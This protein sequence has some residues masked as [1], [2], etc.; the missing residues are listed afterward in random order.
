MTN[1]IWIIGAVISGALGAYTVMYVLIR[2]NALRIQRDAMEMFQ[3]TR[4]ECASLKSETL[5]K[6]ESERYA[7]RKEIEQYRIEEKGRMEILTVRE[8]RLERIEQSIENEKKLLSLEKAKVELLRQNLETT[9]REIAFAQELLQ[10]E[11]ERIAGL[12]Q[13]QALRELLQSTE[14]MYAEDLTARMR[15][16]ELQGNQEWEQRARELLANALQ[17]YAAPHVAETSTTVVNLPADDY[18][19]RIIGK[20]GRNIKALEMAT[21]VEIIVDEQPGTVLI[22]GFNPLRRHVAKRALEKLIADGRVQ[23]TKIEEAVALAKEEIADDIQKAGEEALAEAGLPLLDPR[24]VAALGRL[25]YRTSY[26]QNVL[27]HSLEV[28]HIGGMLAEQLGADTWICRLGGL[29]HDIGKAVDHEVKGGHPEIGY[30][31]MKKYGLS[32]EIAYMSLAHHE[33][34]PRTLEGIIC[35]VA[36]KVSGGRPGARRDSL[37][38]YV[39]RLE[40]IEAIATRRAGIDRAFALSA[41]RELRVIVNAESVDDWQATLLARDIARDIENELT[42]PGE[43]KINVIREKRVIEYAR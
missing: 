30:D 37:E 1:F 12:S 31:M 41:G 9:Q 36:D 34:S 4:D 7:L 15:K 17:R 23:P 18:K 43:I 3:K 6:V 5:K 26:G 13:E 33:T 22:S 16:L 32:E 35:L 2:R 39:R 14:K 11:K 21:G 10:K 29:L 38:E 20:E 25:K 8:T 40:D 19:G 27:R 42:Y 24:L 28:S